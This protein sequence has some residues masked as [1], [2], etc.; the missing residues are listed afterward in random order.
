MSVVLIGMMGV[1]KTTLGRAASKALGWKFID[2]DRQIE[3]EQQRTIPAIFS[4]DG[5]PSFRRLET[6]AISR[7]AGVKHAVVST[8]GGA[9]VEPGNLERMRE[10]GPV[11]Y[12]EAGADALIRRLK[13]SRTRRPMLGDDIDG[14][15]VHLLQTRSETY[16]RAD[17]RVSVDERS[18][19]EVVLEI[20]R[21]A[22]EHS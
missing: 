18:P 4:E 13:N 12:L 10:I 16:R 9:P 14:R 15:V 2:I 7:L 1:G 5:E 8:G 3:Q 22:E 6:E 11:V 21:I 19:M 17:F 20:K